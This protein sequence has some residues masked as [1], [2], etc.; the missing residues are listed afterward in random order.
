MTP[1]LRN[2]AL[3]ETRGGQVLF[4]LPVFVPLIFLLQS[5]GGRVAAVDIYRPL[6]EV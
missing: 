4:Y 2:V 3:H 6:V 5:A 1:A